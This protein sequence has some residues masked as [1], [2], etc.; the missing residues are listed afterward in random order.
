MNLKPVIEKVRQFVYEQ[1]EQFSA[2]PR[3]YLDLSTEKGQWLAEKLGVNKEIVLLGTLL[4]DCQLGVA[5]KE[6][7]QAEHIEMSAKEAEILLSEFPEL[8]ENTKT[9][10]LSCVRQHHGANKFDSLEAEIC[11]NADCYR[12]ASVTGFVGG[13]RFTRDMPLNDLVKLL[14]VKADEKWNALSIDICKKELEPEYKLIKN[15]IKSYE[16]GKN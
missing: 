13:L 1:S 9:N 3:F 14:S 2:P 8:E 6:G 4:M 11:C 15:L 12:F 7:R 10:I 5:L 16:K